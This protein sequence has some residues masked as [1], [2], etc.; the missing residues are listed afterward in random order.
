MSEV[1]ATKIVDAAMGSNAAAYIQLVTTSGMSYTGSAVMVPCSR[2]DLHMGVKVGASAKAF[3]QSVGDADKEIFGKDLTR[4]YPSENA[5][6][7]GGA[8]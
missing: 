1:T 8:Q 3:G 2:T 5:L 4:V 7:G 6:C